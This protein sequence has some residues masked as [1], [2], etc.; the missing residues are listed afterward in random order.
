LAR[1]AY[2]DA[3][4]FIFDDPLSAL[5]PEV[6][7]KVFDECILGMLK[8]KT[9]LLVTNQLQCLSRCDSIIALGNGGRVLEQGTF[10]DLNNSNGEVT[11][12]LKGVA[13]SRRNIK[14]DQSFD[15]A[16]V[17]NHLKETKKLISNEERQTGT[18]KLG[19]Y[20]KY[21]ESGGGWVSSS[22]SKPP[23]LHS[24]LLLVLKYFAFK[25]SLLIAARLL[26]H[27]ILLHLIDWLQYWG[28]RLGLYLDS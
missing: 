12:L 11:R 16:S 2:A 3:D 25:C 20:L 23:S 22:L 10:I 13:P 6:A 21:I 7:E 15:R 4:V 5:D 24:L 26:W 9:R 17:R 14:E 1:A 27:F 18:V 19:V 28:D 8:G